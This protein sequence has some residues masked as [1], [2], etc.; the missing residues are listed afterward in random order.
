[1]VGLSDGRRVFIRPIV[2]ADAPELGEAIRAADP[3]TLH[4]RFLGAPPKVTPRLL[5]H[6]TSVD[7]LHRFA[8]VARDARTGH[9]VAVARYEGSGDSTAEVAVVVHPGW[10]RVG[11]AT[12]LVRLLARAAINRGF[13]A[14]SA[15][16]LAENRPV[17]AL[18]TDAGGAG[19]A[20][21]RQGL[22]EAKIAPERERSSRRCALS[23]DLM[24]TRGCGRG[25]WAAAAVAEWGQGLAGFATQH[26]GPVEGLMFQRGVGE[27][28]PALG[29]ERAAGRGALFRFA[30]QPGVTSSSTTRWVWSE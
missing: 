5:E 9:G 25:R 19:T 30:E 11:L 18:L 16:Y 3:E 27:L 10:R 4:R 6:L 1:M 24:N 28:G 21:I 14:F 7:Y 23:A 29:G 22:A 2:P 13:H 26:R 20:L 8:L 12:V 17:A 15:S